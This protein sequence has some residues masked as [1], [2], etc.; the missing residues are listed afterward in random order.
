MDAMLQGPESRWRVTSIAS[1]PR[2]SNRSKRKER[3]G[4]GVGE[5]RSTKQLEDQCKSSNASRPMH[6]AFTMRID[7]CAFVLDYS[8]SLH[9]MQCTCPSLQCKRHRVSSSEGV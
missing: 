9:C 6:V 3:V 2:Q 1:Q 8:A 7:R 4:E 5:S